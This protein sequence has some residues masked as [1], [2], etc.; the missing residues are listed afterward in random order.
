MVLSVKEPAAVELLD[1][2]DAV[3]R[4]HLRL[5]A[6]ETDMNGA[7]DAYCAAA[8]GM[9]ETYL[10]RRLITQ[11]LTLTRTGFPWSAIC[12]GVG[13]VA[14]IDQ[15]TYRDDAGT[16]QTVASSVY[17]LD[18][19]VEPAE[20]R[21]V[22]GQV[23][24]VPDQDRANVRVDFVIGYGSASSSVPPEIVQA[25]RVLIAHMFDSPHPVEIGQ[26][27]EEMPCSVRSRLDPYRVFV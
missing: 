18:D 27:V 5:E 4:K 13:P 8:R 10:R 14:S 15:I 6:D 24:P 25:A 3:L 12:L 23:W 2:S 9:I 11:T 16:W 1:S 19:S 17:R 21:P 26:S 7:V 22:F 20:V